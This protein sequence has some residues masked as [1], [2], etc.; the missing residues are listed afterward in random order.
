MEAP[1]PRSVQCCEGQIRRRPSSLHLP[2]GHSSRVWGCLFRTHRLRLLNTQLRSWENPTHPRILGNRSMGP[3]QVVA[4]SASGVH[5]RGEWGLSVFLPACSKYDWPL[6]SLLQSCKCLSL[7]SPRPEAGEIQRK[8]KFRIS[9][10]L[11]LKWN[12]KLHTTQI[13]RV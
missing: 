12:Y 5:L 8:Q 4:G 3:T 9:L 13:L 10:F 1:L 11:F 2:I 6:W 7:C